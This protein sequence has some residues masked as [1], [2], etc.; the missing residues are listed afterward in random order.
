MSH[1]LLGDLRRKCEFEAPANINRGQFPSLA[2]IIRFKFRALK[3][4]GGCF[5]IGLRAHRYVFASSHRHGTG[6]Q[7][8]DTRYHYG[9]VSRARCCDTGHKARC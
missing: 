7:T 8:G 9:A 6:D 1:Q 4:E 2:Q 3:R 5:G